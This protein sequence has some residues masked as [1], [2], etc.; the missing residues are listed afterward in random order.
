MTEKLQKI[1][2]ILIDPSEIYN[3]KTNFVRKMGNLLP[4]V[5]VALAGPAIIALVFYRR[6]A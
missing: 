6:G 1:H 2:F 3:T 5:A 4:L